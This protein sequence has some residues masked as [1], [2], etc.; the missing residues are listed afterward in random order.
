MNKMAG[1]A[2]LVVLL[3]VG[4]WWAMGSNSNSNSDSTSYTVGMSWLMKET[5]DVMTTYK[6]FEVLSVEGD[7]VTWRSTVLNKDKEPFAG[8]KGRALTLPMIS[9]EALDPG[10]EE[11]LSAAG[12]SFRCRKIVSAGGTVW[13]SLAYPLITIKMRSG[14]DKNDL[15]EWKVP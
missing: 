9:V 6:R 4:A 12:Q 14:S 10:S 15:V 3:G 5:N 1:V 13:R 8:D 11:T 7:K 2:I